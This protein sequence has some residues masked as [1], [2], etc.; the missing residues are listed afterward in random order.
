MVDNW[1]RPVSDQVQGMGR[2]ANEGEQ[3][4]RGVSRL[5]QRIVASIE[6]Y[7]LGDQCTLR[8]GAVKKERKEKR[9][10]GQTREGLTSARPIITTSRR[11][12]G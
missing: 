11:E 5:Q 12:R 10:S 2:M 3:S 4:Q 9:E 8:S 7:K 6:R 1:V